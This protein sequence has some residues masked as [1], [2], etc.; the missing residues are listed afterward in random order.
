MPR[1]YPSGDGRESYILNIRPGVPFAEFHDVEKRRDGLPLN[2]FSYIRD[3]VHLEEQK[4]LDTE[5]RRIAARMEYLSGTQSKK[6]AGGAVGDEIREVKR[7]EEVDRSQC[8]N[9][10]LH[11]LYALD[12]ERWEEE[13]AGR[14]LATFKY[15][16]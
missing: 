13:L 16:Q 7:M 14:G 3:G 2:V 5:E 4:R 10:Q 8:R 15:I 9:K 1:Y 12:R 6:M 11:A